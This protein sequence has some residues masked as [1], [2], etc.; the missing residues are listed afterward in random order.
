M[1]LTKSRELDRCWIRYTS[2][3]CL[4]LT[5]MISMMTAG[6]SKAERGGPKSESQAATSPIAVFWHYPGFPG[7]D[8]PVRAGLLAAAWQDGRVVRLET[9]DDLGRKYVTGM[10]GAEDTQRLRTLVA[11]DVAFLTEHKAP[12]VPEDSA[13]ERI[14]VSDIG[15]SARASFEASLAPPPLIADLRAIMTTAPLADM[16]EA[17]AQWEHLRALC[18]SP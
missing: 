1:S 16:K 17:P 12:L 18:G 14:Y 9:H 8:Q 4:V 15:K 5:G 2:L 7:P 13:F 11:Q 10:L 3:V 6:C